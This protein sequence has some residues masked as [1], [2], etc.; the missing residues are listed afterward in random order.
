[1]EY[2][3]TNSTLQK[4]THAGYTRHIIHTN[5]R[6]YDQDGHELASSDEDSSADADVAE[7]DPYSEV[8][9]L[10]MHRIS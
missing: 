3:N 8:D 9:I 6:R 5:P 4:I 2:H 7:K 10:S 1:M